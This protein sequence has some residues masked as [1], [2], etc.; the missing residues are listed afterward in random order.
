MVKSRLQPDWLQTFSQENMHHNST[1]VELIDLDITYKH[2]YTYLFLEIRLEFEEL[3]LFLLSRVIRGIR[4][5][6]RCNTRNTTGL[7]TICF[8]FRTHS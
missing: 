8:T 5:G 1:N 2:I 4:Q 7:P 6:C 3:F